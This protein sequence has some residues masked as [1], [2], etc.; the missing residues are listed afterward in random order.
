M[1]LKEK[2]KKQLDT[3]TPTLN[4]PYYQAEKCEK[5]ADE[6]AIEFVNWIVN[7][8]TTDLLHDLELFGEI[9]KEVTSKKLLE[10]YK[11]EKGL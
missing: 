5:I 4:R 9:D 11:Q 1:T 8:D 10:I 3:A 6:F 7:P 2:F